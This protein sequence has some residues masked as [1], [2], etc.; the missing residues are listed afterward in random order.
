CQQFLFV[1][2]CYLAAFHKNLAGVRREQPRRDAEKDRFARAGNPGYADHLSAFEPEAYVVERQLILEAD[3]DVA[4][5]DG[6]IH[7]TPVRTSVFRLF[8]DNAR[9]DV[10]ELRGPK[11]H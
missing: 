10:G 4:K 5:F 9:Y 7:M 1:E 3:G 6:S 2:R 8:Q 11:A